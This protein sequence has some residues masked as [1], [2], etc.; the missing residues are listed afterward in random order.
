MFGQATVGSWNGPVVIVCA[1][2]RCGST[3]VIEDMRNTGQLGNPEEWFLSWRAETTQVNWSQA[4]NNVLRKST[5]PNG[6][7]AIKIMANQASDVDACLR[8]AASNSAP[9]D[10]SSGPFAALRQTFDGAVWVRLRR[11][12]VVE[13]AVSRVMSRE[14]GINH[15]TGRPE[16]DH[17]AGNLARGLPPDYNA[18]TVYHFDAILTEVTA[19]IL[20]NLAWD[21]FFSAHQLEP[22]TLIYEDIAADANMRHLDLMAAALGLS[23]VPRRPRKMIKLSNELNR[24]WVERFYTDCERM[25]FSLPKV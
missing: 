15:A 3:M 18:Q 14:T 13:Q 7:A 8:R 23:N 21:R 6:V 11:H 22:L 17:F 25:R 10:A 19:I 16:D 1:T 9:A 4:L 12:G 2:Q 20:E 24:A 5:G